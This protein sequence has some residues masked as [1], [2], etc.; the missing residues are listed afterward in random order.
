MISKA[1]T[2]VAAWVFIAV[3]AVELMEEGRR[4]LVVIGAEWVEL[5]AGHSGRR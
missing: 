2:L 4:A 5:A 3:G 1:V